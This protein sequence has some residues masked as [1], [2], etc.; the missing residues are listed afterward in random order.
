MQENLPPLS[1]LTKLFKVGIDR[2]DI[3]LETIS[4]SPIKLKLLSV[5]LFSPQ[6]LPMQLEKQV[7]ARDLKAVEMVFSGQFQGNTQLVFPKQTASILIDL[8]ES[9]DRRKLDKGAFEKAIFSE[10]GNIFYNGMMGVI[11]TLCEYG[12]TYMIPK[13]KEGDLRSLLLGN[14]SP[15]YSVALIGTIEI[16]RDRNLVFWFQFDTLEKL[17]EKSNDLEDYFD[18]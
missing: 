14:L 18:L 5:D 11:S 9:E 15:K 4:R 10:V 12:I 17:L 7:G 6:Q 1:V 16:F 2:A 3:M 13:Y 8:I